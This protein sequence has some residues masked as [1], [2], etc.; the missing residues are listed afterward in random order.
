MHW[1][2]KHARLRHKLS[3]YIDDQLTASETAALEAHLASCDA[4]RR[5]L[6]ELRATVSALHEQQQAEAPRSFAITPGRLERKSAA[7]ARPLPALGL[8]MRLA[9]AGVALA[10]SIVVVGDLTLGDNGGA[11][12]QAGSQ[13]AEESRAVEMFSDAETSKSSE[14]GAYPPPSGNADSSTTQSNAGAAAPC[15]PAAAPAATGGGAAGGAGT[16]AGRGVGET[17]APS[18]TQQPAPSSTPSPES[19]NVAAICGNAS[20]GAAVP[21]A[22]QTPENAAPRA[23]ADNDGGGISTLRIAEIALAGVLVAIVAAIVL[24]AA[25]RRRRIA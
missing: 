21:I 11:S 2:N 10:L 18:A 19:P 17:P 8:G 13:P 23:T 14:S 20:G 1:L 9:G 24:E 15:P 3:P 7:A 16:T 4:C 22:P 12:P 6:D 25:M 5:R